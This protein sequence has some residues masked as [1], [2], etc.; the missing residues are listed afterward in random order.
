MVQSLQGRAREERMRGAHVDVV[1]AAFL[2]AFH[3]VHDRGARIDQVFDNDR[4]ATVTSPITWVM[5]DSLC[6]WRFL[7]MIANGESR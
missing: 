1:G 4:R 2:E 5:S 6:A 3:D 7:I